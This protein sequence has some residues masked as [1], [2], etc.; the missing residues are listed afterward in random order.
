MRA[1][2]PIALGALA[3]CGSAGAG[4]LGTEGGSWS[5]AVA[6]P[7]GDVRLEHPAQPGIERGTFDLE[8]VS[9][10]LDGDAWRLEATFASPVPTLTEVRAAR[11]RVVTMVPMTI[12]VY[13]DTTPDAGRVEAL[14]GRGFRVSAAEAWDRALVVTSVPDL[15]DDDVVHARTVTARGR[16]LV[17]TFPRAAVPGAIRGALVVVLATSPSGD[18]RVRQVGRGGECRVWDD[19]RCTLGGED[20]PVLDALAVDVAR[21]R[22][23]A[24][25]YRDG[26][27]PVS[28]TTPVVFQRG[29]LFGAAPVDEDE[30]AKGRLATLLDA[31]GKPL[32]TAIVVSVVGDTASLELVSPAEVEGATAVVFAA[33]DEGAQ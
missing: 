7:I 3:A 11:D 13:L 27:R 2:S 8:R 14:E 16:R 29:Q 6:D 30:V 31:D 15:S 26:A 10:A 23:L 19:V 5:W 32:G 12:D 24:L 18:G 22:P 33:R 4:G 21:G 25:V 20:P 17:A 28:R 1:W 9:L